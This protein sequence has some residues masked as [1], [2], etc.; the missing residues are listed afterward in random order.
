[1][2]MTILMDLLLFTVL[3]SVG[4]LATLCAARIFP[5][6]LLELA[7]HHG[8]F[9]GLE[10]AAPPPGSGGGKGGRDWSAALWAVQAD[11]ARRGSFSRQPLE[12]GI[13]GPF[14]DPVL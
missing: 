2:D 6:R 14:P 5:L 7:Q 4:A 12:C 10:G 13:T 8:R 11:A 1:M 3:L 9:A